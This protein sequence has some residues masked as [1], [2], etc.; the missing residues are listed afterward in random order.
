MILDKPEISVEKKMEPKDQWTM[1]SH[2]PAKSH[3]SHVSL[4]HFQSTHA[5]PPT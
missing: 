4:T 1:T 5:F 2:S 3:A